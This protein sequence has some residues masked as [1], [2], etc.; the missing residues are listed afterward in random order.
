MKKSLHVFNSCHWEEMRNIL[1]NRGTD[2][3]KGLLQ[4][5]EF[6]TERDFPENSVCWI[7][8][9]PALFIMT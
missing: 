6:A 8:T 7:Y 2:S 9:I 3:Q 1:G 5:V 4:K